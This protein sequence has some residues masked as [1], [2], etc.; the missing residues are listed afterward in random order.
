MTCPRGTLIGELE[1]GVRTLNA[2]CIAEWLMLG[3]R[4]S[5]GFLF[6]HFWRQPCAVVDVICIVQASERACAAPGNCIW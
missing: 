4:S 1:Y 6:N 2:C 3:P 5:T